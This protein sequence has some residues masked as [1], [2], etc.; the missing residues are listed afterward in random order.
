MKASNSDELGKPKETKDQI[1]RIQGRSF[2]N[3]RKISFLCENHDRHSGQNDQNSI[4]HGNGVNSLF[5]GVL[6]DEPDTESVLTAEQR[7]VR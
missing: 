6:P 2:F 7:V 1:S 5:R 3:G 4:K